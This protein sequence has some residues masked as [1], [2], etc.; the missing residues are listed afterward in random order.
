MIEG[1]FCCARLT[2]AC[3]IY[4]TCN[5]EQNK[6][7][8]SCLHYVLDI[9]THSTPCSTSMSWVFWLG[10]IL[11][12]TVPCSTS[13]KTEHIETPEMLE[14]M[15]LRRTVR[16]TL[17]FPVQLQKVWNHFHTHLRDF[18][19]FEACQGNAPRWWQMIFHS[20]QNG[21][22]VFCAHLRDTHR[23]DWHSLSVK[24]MDPKYCKMPMTAAI[25]TTD[26][27]SLPREITIRNFI[28]KVISFYTT[29]GLDFLLSTS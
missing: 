15:E 14:L 23:R 18:I 12:N 2:A 7:N 1:R 8:F 28:E 9:N 3:C 20:L 27:N 25:I 5:I 29:V 6:Q 24:V 4:R 21:T 26:V 11:A 17:T 10:A 19:P 22:S 16:A 13:L